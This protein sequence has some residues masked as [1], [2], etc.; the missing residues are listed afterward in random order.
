MDNI[1]IMFSVFE[2]REA[3]NIRFL[4]ELIV[5]VEH[6]FEINLETN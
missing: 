2:S 3:N 1:F 4:N 6:W 5:R